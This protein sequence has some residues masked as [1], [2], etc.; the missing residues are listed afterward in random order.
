[1]G[2]VYLSEY[3]EVTMKRSRRS[4]LE[5]FV[6]LPKCNQKFLIFSLLLHFLIFLLMEFIIFFSHVTMCY[7]MAQLVKCLAHSFW[8]KWSWVRTLDEA[9]FFLI[10]FFFSFISY[11]FY[12]VL[13]GNTI[14]KQYFHLSNLWTIFC[15]S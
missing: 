10:F 12:K 13:L 6:Q 8:S 9:D 3:A 1:M 7:V 11:I 4:L 15:Y 2:L 5:L 14:V